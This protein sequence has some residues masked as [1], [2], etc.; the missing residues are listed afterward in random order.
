MGQSICRPGEPRQCIIVKSVLVVKDPVAQKVTLHVFDDV[1]NLA[2]A[3]WI[4]F[5]AE[6][7]F[8][9]LGLDV[10]TK[11]GSEDQVT[12][13]L[14]NQQNFVL[15][16]DNL[17]RNAPEEL[18]CFFVREFCKFGSEMPSGKPKIFIPG[19]GQHHA[20]EEYLYPTISRRTQRIFT[21]I[22]LGLLAIRKF[23]NYLILTEVLND[24]NVVFISDPVHKVEH[25]LCTYHGK[26]S[27]VLL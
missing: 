16:I 19:A 18:K 3:F 8:E 5:P 23:R 12:V 4:G 9:P 10:L 26:I 13:V 27:M 2:F 20:E 15:I 22:N 6:V 14:I 25:R 7:S 1:F 24:R 17:L 11:G 21:K